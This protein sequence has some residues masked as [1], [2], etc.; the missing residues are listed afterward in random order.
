MDIAL[1]GICFMLD[2]SFE[3]K[4]KTKCFK[5]QQDKIKNLPPI[6]TLEDRLC[7]E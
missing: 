1:Q 2:L 4:I 5:T 6:Q 7:A 3:L